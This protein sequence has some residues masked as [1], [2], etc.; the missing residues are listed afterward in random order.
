MR[1]GDVFLCELLI[2]SLLVLSL[3]ADS[4][5]VQPDAVQHTQHCGPKEKAVSRHTPTHRAVHKHTRAHSRA[6]NKSETNRATVGQREGLAQ[7]TN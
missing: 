3:P 1:V 7:L 5:S 2:H 6:I 4:V